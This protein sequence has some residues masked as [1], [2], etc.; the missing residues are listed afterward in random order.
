MFVSMDTLSKSPT[1][2]LG[3]IDGALVQRSL[4]SWQTAMVTEYRD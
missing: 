1:S 3:Y 4:I 2:L